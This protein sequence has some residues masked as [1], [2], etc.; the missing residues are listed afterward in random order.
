MGVDMRA[1]RAAAF[2]G[3][4]ALI[5][6][7]VAVPA[8]PAMAA[9]IPVYNSYELQ[10]AFN[11]A[12]DGDTVVIAAEFTD[13]TGVL[14]LPGGKTLILDVGESFTLSTIRLSPG[15]DLTIT[16]AAGRVLT[17]SSGGD[18]AAIRTTDA[19]LTIGGNVQ[20]SATSTGNGA[21]IGGDAGAIG[22]TVTI[23]GTSTVSAT[24]GAQ[25]AGIGGGRFSAGGRIFIA[26]QAVVTASA[27]DGSAIGGGFGGAAGQIEISGDASVSA[28]A[29]GTGS[30]IGGAS[31]GVGEEDGSVVITD[32]AQVTASA[33]GTGSAI[34]GQASEGTA[35]T[36]AGDANVTASAA[37]GPA[38]GNPGDEWARKPVII[39]GTPTVQATSVSGPG[40]GGTGTEGSDPFDG[41]TIAGGMVTASSDSGPGIG[42]TG[43]GGAGPVIT[44]GT[45][46]ATSASGPG[47]GGV[48]GG[49]GPLISG[50]DVTATST[51]GPGI[52]G[53][54][55]WPVISGGVVTATS[56]S[57]PGIGNVGNLTV[58]G[59]S[60]TATSSTGPGIGPGPTGSSDFWVSITDGDVTAESEGAGAGIGGGF[61][62]PGVN[63]S[64]SGGTVTAVAGPD[65]HDRMAS[66]IGWGAGDGEAPA[67][68]FLEVTGDG[69][70]VV[71][72][73]S[74][75]TVPEGVTVW[76]DENGGGSIRS[77][78][79]GAKVENFGAIQQAADN[80]DWQAGLLDVQPNNFLITLDPNG[81][82]PEQE[83]RVFA[84]TFL[85]GARDVPEDPTR[86]GFVFEHWN[87]EADG[88][89]DW[90]FPGEYAYWDRDITLYA[91][92]ALATV[93]TATPVGRPTAGV[94]L[95]FD[96]TVSPADPTNPGI[97]SGV[98][99]L[100]IDGEFIGIAELDADGRATVTWPN[101]TLGEHTYNVWYFPDG[102]PWLFSET[103]ELPLTVL[104]PTPTPTPTPP[105]PAPTPPGPTPHPGGLAS[106][107]TDGGLL[108][109]T[110]ALALAAILLG[111]GMLR[112]R[113]A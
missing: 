66:A 20:V 6:A 90:V 112:R 2:L 29:S 73:G 43:S 33:T 65:V 74:T 98:A 51:S 78:G 55:T 106:T 25:S 22:G 40:I 30:A 99:E 50:G 96:V 5:G 26:D 85:E 21:A 15:S 52:G 94:P 68:G 36:I 83:V 109:G 63:V 62:Q 102:A 10:Q 44:G 45:V 70:V 92:W 17:V 75:L 39:E 9:T 111:A 41:L 88:S 86:D 16:S 38:I 71:G 93:T 23:G 72:A 32:G 31:A 87:T 104:A 14:D 12:A 108:G 89:G 19:K 100:F 76:S 64:V 113:R 59:G 103:P 91:Q 24:G 69:T 8:T 67:W 46:T 60:V 11:E 7:L 48:P 61:D 34:G 35:V 79:D 105:T 110:A 56:T 81:G 37:S 95:D 58:D 77:G 57:G 42:G 49:S 47:L 27:T 107:G 18:S 82:E 13:T 1:K 80:V 53:G 101:P 54:S 28:T 3:G 84:H 4:A 97:P